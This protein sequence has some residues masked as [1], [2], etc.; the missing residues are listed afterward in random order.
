[1]NPG[2][3]VGLPLITIKSA[4]FTSENKIN[5]QGKTFCQGIVRNFWTNSNVATLNYLLI[6]LPGWILI[7]NPVTDNSIYLRMGECADF[8]TI[9]WEYLY[10]LK[11]PCILEDLYSKHGK[12]LYPVV[13]IEQPS[14]WE[15]ISC[16]KS[17]DSQSPA[18]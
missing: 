3:V 7:T 11:E 13:M 18:S 5:C 15:I 4:F 10:W 17:V 12:Y 6:Q 16:E 9:S 14:T 8:K 2:C 1:M